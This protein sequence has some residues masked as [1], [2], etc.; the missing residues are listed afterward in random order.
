M[1]TFGIG[2]QERIGRNLVNHRVGGQEDAPVRLPER[3]AARRVTGGVQQ[4]QSRRT[5]GQFGQLVYGTKL[6]QRCAHDADLLELIVLLATEFVGDSGFVHDARKKLTHSRVGAELSSFYWV[7]VN[8]G[9]GQ[10]GERHGDAYVVD[11]EI[12]EH[13]LAQG[14]RVDTALA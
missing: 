3:D 14:A 7:G 8:R 6:L 13:D 9:A 1:E 5:A 10:L 12:G 11:V 2:G 4:T